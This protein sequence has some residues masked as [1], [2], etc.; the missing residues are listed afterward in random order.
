MKACNAAWHC[1]IN[2]I[3]F[4]IKS[5]VLI[6]LYCLFLTKVELIFWFYAD[7]SKLW[8]SKS[9][10]NLLFFPPYED[11]NKHCSIPSPPCSVR[12]IC[13]LDDFIGSDSIIRAFCLVR[14]F[15]SVLVASSSFYDLIC[16]LKSHVVQPCLLKC[17]Q[18]LGVGWSCSSSR[19]WGCGWGCT[20]LGISGKCWRCTDT[21]LA[22][23]ASA[24]V[25][26]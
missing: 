25:L 23:I 11:G 14:G 24:N 12:N 2:T 3:A 22:C 10:Q 19:G 17:Q 26:M 15:T 18:G 9:F 4:T 7:F 5:K 16:I 6:I 13:V 8:V 21:E 20:D 1:G